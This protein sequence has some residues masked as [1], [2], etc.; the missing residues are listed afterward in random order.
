MVFEYVDLVG[1]G[2]GVVLCGDYEDGCDVGECC[3]E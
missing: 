1:F 3:G 2:V